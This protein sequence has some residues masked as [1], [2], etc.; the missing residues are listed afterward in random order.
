MSLSPEGSNMVF[1]K[2]HHNISISASKKKKKLFYPCAR[3]YACVESSVSVDIS[4]DVL[5]AVSSPLAKNSK[6]CSTPTFVK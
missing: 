2:S 6:H 5:E 3:A 1:I 4:T